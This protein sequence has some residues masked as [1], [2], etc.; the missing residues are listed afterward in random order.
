MID[1]FPVI[2]DNSGGRNNMFSLI[3]ENSCYRRMFSDNAG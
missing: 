2:N 1:T 3:R